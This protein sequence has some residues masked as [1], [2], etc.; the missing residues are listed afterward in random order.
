MFYKYAYTV[1]DILT[2]GKR[3]D[4]DEFVACYNP[5]NRH[6]RVPTWSEN[7]PDGRWRDYDY[8]TLISRDKASLDLFWLKDDSLEDSENL[9]EPDVLAQEIVED[10]QAA[11]EQFSLI[12]SDLSASGSEAAV[13]S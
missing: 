7:N 5:R 4:L 1:S 6:E 9:P 10:L 2:N 12:A 13:E 11:L 3:P 8:E